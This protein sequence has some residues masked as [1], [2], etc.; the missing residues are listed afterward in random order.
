MMP[1]NMLTKIKGEKIMPITDKSQ[2]SQDEKGICGFTSMIQM[3][4]DNHK[5]TLSDFIRIYGTSTAFA[6]EWLR[7]QIDHDR[8]ELNANVA[9]ALK[10]SLLFTGDFG[11]K[12]QISLDQLLKENHWDWSEKPGFAL[13]PEAI[14]DYVLRKFRMEMMIEIYSPYKTMDQLW[15]STSNNLGAG[16]YGIMTDNGA[17]PNKDQIQHYIYIDNN[18][19]LMTWQKTGQT[20][21][22]ALIDNGFTKVVTRLYPK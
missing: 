14:C 1:I 22:Q 2:I 15:S 8:L 19:V 20:A 9:T 16:I 7:I 3:L 10:Q 4:I 11:A 17:G 18:G 12:Y 13:I 6:D 5:L 21:K